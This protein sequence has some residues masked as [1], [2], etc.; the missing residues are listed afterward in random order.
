MRLPRTVAFDDTAFPELMEIFREIDA[1][2]ATMV[3]T[4]PGFQARSTPIRR[5]RKPGPAQ[6][7]SRR[8]S[9]QR[10]AA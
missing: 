7:P 8:A 1:G 6:T 4:D 2:I 10:V 5:N 3:A 9:S